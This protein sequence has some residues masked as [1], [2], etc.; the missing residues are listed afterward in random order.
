MTETI[1]FRRARVAQSVRALSLVRCV[2][3]EY[4]YIA[5]TVLARTKSCAYKEKL[6]SSSPRLAVVRLMRLVFYMR[7]R[8]CVRKREREK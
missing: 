4:V 8:V 1:E 2:C 3:A 7:L 5:R 6:F